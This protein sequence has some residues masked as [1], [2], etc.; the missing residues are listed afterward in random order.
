MG[1]A[2]TRSFAALP[3]AS[4]SFPAF[5]TA[6][7]A[8]VLNTINMKK[9]YLK[10]GSWYYSLQDGSIVYRCYISPGNGHSGI[11]FRIKYN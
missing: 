10:G 4:T 1:G 7:T 6:A 5:G 9:L 8:S 11:D 3:I 2:A